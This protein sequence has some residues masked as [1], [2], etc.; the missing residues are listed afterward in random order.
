M[1]IIENNFKHA[2][3]KIVFRTWLEHDSRRHTHTHTHTHIYIYIQHKY[4]IK[5]WMHLHNTSPTGSLIGYSIH[6]ALSH[7][8]GK[9]LSKLLLP[10]GQGAAQRYFLSGL[11]LVWILN[12]PFETEYVTKAKELNLPYYLP[13]ARGWIDE[14][15]CFPRVLTGSEMQ[16]HPGFELGPPSLFPTMITDILNVSLSVKLVVST[17]NVNVFM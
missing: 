15:I 8:K 9:R 5:Q 2:R 3:W 10:Y 11:K 16:S 1:I 13:T 14:F 6:M 17:S 12:F 7:I 4:R